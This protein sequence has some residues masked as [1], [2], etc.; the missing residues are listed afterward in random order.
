VN[1]HDT[2]PTKCTNLFL[3]LLNYNI[4]LNIPTC[5]SLQGTITME[6]NQSNT[7]PRFSVVNLLSVMNRMNNIKSIWIYW[8]IMNLKIGSWD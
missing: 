4:T 1:I 7:I 5:C 2:K 3:I 6:S 8:K